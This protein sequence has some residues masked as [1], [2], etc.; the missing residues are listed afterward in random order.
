MQ[1]GSNT[2]HTEEKSA[3]SLHA[4]SQILIRLNKVWTKGHGPVHRRLVR[5]V[6]EDGRC[7]NRRCRGCGLTAT[8][9]MFNI[10]Y[11]IRRIIKNTKGQQPRL[12]SCSPSNVQLHSRGVT[13]DHG[14]HFRTPFAVATSS[15]SLPF[16]KLSRCSQFIKQFSKSLKTKWL[17]SFSLVLSATS[18][19][20]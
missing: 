13:R 3:C 1:Q 6:R 7:N 14:N 9:F 17:K 20:P 2:S 10:V 19:S 12:K 15:N 18:A 5:E 4:S 11:P 8:T 16:A